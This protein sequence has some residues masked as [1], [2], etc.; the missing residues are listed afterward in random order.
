MTAAVLVCVFGLSSGQQAG[1]AGVGLGQ[2][3]SSLRSSPRAPA[4]I[5]RPSFGGRPINNL[6]AFNRPLPS[7]PVGQVGPIGAV[8]SGP[9]G[10]PLQSRPIQSV[11]GK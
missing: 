3:I 11:S 7:S 8:P 5:A 10:L 1:L 4:L 9:V 6:N 2:P